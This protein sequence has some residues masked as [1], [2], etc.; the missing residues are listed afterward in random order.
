MTDNKFKIQIKDAKLRDQLLS[1]L[2]QDRATILEVYTELKKQVV[3]K[4][5]YA[6]HGLTLAKFLEILTKQTNQVLDLLK[7]EEKNKGADQ[8][9]LTED[10]VESVYEASQKKIQ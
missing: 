10:L 6:L 5:D 3:D 9:T 8:G 1:Q 4:N 2:D 7:S